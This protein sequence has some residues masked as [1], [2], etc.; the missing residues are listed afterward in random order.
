MTGAINLS[1]FELPSTASDRIRMFHRLWLETGAGN[2][3]DATAFD[4]AVLSA[5]Y[6]LLA[7]I[8]MDQ[9]ARRLVWLE[10]AV[11]DNWPFGPPV[12][13]APVQDCVP[14][15]SIK[16]V[17]RSFED[18]LE[19]SIPDY[20]ETTS[21]M[22]GGT[23]VSMARLVAPILAGAGRQ[24]IALWDIIEPPATSVPSRGART[25]PAKNTLSL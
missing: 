23:S 3:P 24:L 18:T 21:W 22:H 4:F 6:P 10:L 15:L 20:F 13:N 9:T 11:S 17:L 12:V 8:G 25:R 16:R 7:R 19:T 1:S 2:V 14:P 5:D